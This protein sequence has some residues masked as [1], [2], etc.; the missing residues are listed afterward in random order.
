MADTATEAAL[1]DFLAAW[2]KRAFRIA[3]VATGHQD[4]ALDIVQDAMMKL[5]RRYRH[6]QQHEWAPLLQRILQSTIRDWYRRQRV[7]NQWRQLFGGQ[8][9][10]GNE[11][12]PHDTHPAPASIEPESQVASDSAMR[13]LDEALR[14]L[15]LRQ[16]QVFL[17]RQWE[18]LDVT[19]T[20]Q[21]M[22]IT[23]GSVK[24]H[25]S[26]ALRALRQQL[27]GHWP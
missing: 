13:A 11:P 3:M 19:Q 27:E 1:A 4:E 26:R 24:T 14:V 25:Y 18:G 20:A 2:E 7:R 10:E 17:L 9:D 8:R 6:R 12:D 5:V 16:Q 21:A 22:G 15:P 23:Q